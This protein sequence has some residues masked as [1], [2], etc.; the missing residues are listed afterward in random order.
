MEPVIGIDLGT[1]NTCVAG[2]VAGTP[3]VFPGTGGHNTTPS[4]F[5]VDE[6]GRWMVGHGARRQAITNSEGTVWAFKR[7]IGRQW[8]SPDQVR[9]SNQ[10]PYQLVKGPGGDVRFNLRGMLFS[11]PEVAASIIAEVKGNAEATLGQSVSKAVITVPAY[12]NNTRR[13]A[14]KNAGEIAGLEVLQVINEPTA[15]AL[16]FG[17]GRQ[18][19]K[20]VLV[21]DLGGGTFDVSVLRITEGVF[22]VL[23]TSGDSYL[24]VEDFDQ[25]IVDYLTSRMKETHGIDPRSDG[26]L[27]QRLREA[28]EQ[29]KCELS[30]AATTEIH[31]P[32][33]GSGAASAHFH[34]SLDREDLE[35]LCEDLIERTV[36]TCLRALEKAGLVRDEIDEIIL[37]GG[38]TRMPM[39][40]SRVSELFGKEPRKNVHPDEVVALGAALH[41]EALLDTRSFGDSGND[42]ILKDVTPLSLGISIAEDFFHVLIP[43]NTAVPVSAS[44]VFTTVRDGQTSARVTLLQGESG[45]AEENEVLGEFMLTG[46]REAPRGEV[47]VKVSIDISEDGMVSVRA[48]D[49]ETGKE[50]AIEVTDTTG[51]SQHEID[52]ARRS[53]QDEVATASFGEADELVPVQAAD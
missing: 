22:D 40:Q 20:Q 42:V 6:E 9:F 19:N 36:A 30:M 47:A 3:Q 32:F 29:A 23:A 44:H 35:A 45:L 28:A 24:G 41:G 2:V 14:T 53:V 48:R 25:R 12:F 1:T 11:V 38:Q 10:F 13:Q 43:A 34:E 37:V 49:L 15:A 18:F 5:A 17:V 51:L 31:L 33:V 46:L 27:F 52:E 16:S 26:M 4:V 8:G 21:F 7:L 50:Q 39:I